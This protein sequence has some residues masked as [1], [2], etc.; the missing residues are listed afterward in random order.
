MKYTS[1]RQMNFFLGLIFLSQILIPK[2]KLPKK[3]LSASISHSRLNSSLSS[4]RSHAFQSSVSASRLHADYHK[5]S[6][7][8]LCLTPTIS[9]NILSWEAWDDGG[10]CG[11]RGISVPSFFSSFTCSLSHLCFYPQQVAA[12]MGSRWG[13]LGCWQMDLGTLP[14]V[15]LLKVHFSISIL[16]LYFSLPFSMLVFF[17]FFFFLFNKMAK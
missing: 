13:S 5:L 2:S 11:D 9:G 14:S 10:S 1:R 3:I 12:A 8:Y 6:E 7:F 17:P 4:S 15:L 16:F